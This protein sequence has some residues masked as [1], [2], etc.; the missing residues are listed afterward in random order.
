MLKEFR[1]F[2]IKGNVLDMA[3]GIIL[4]AAFGTVV[5]SLVK[6]V[7]MPPIGLLIGGVDFAALAIPLGNGPDGEP[8]VIGIGLFLNAILSFVIVAFSVFLVVRYFNRM[9]REQEA[10]PAA[11]PAPS[12]EVV[13]LG[14]IRDLLK[15]R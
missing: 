3:V 4:G 9:K 5:Q 6:D 8:V 14:E 7:I 1:E 11:P 12:A 13:L 15:P 10:A 2:A